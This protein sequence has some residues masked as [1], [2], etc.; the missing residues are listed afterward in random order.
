MKQ[1]PWDKRQKQSTI[2]AMFRDFVGTT[3]GWNGYLGMTHEYG[4]T[5]QSRPE[6][7]GYQISGGTSQPQRQY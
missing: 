6:R 5:P 4:F 7:V 1:I 3:W 2:H